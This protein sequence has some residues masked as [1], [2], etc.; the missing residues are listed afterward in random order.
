MKKW[1]YLNL[2]LVLSLLILVFP[3]IWENDVYW[4]FPIIFSI[5]WILG[6]LFFKWKFKKVSFSQK[7]SDS[8]FR[9]IYLFILYSGGLLFLVFLFSLTGWIAVISFFLGIIFIL[10]DKILKNLH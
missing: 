2:H 8:I 3:L 9:N 10:P 4:I 7:I 6:L 1:I 5:V